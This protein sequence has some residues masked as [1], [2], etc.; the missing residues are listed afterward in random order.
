MVVG[1]I[2]SVGTGKASFLSMI[3]KAIQDISD[4]G[5]ALNFP[6]AFKSLWST[7]NIKKLNVMKQN[8]QKIKNSKI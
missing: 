3:F 1:V 2:F 7:N 8:V 5:E 6:T 4:Q